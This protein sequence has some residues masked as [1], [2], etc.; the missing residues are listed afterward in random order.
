[1]S[2]DEHQRH[3]LYNRAVEVLGSEEA[4]ILMAHLP[5]GGYP[6]LATQQDI[7]DLRQNVLDLREEIRESERRVTS[8]LKSFTLWTILTVNLVLVLA[9][10]GIAL[11]TGLGS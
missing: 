3:Q 7:M 1:M 9:I 10:A 11:G 2:V 6:N 4:D 5:P 8:E